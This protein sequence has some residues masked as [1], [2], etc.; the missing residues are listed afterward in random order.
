MVMRVP[1]LPSFSPRS[2]NDCSTDTSWERRNL[3]MGM[4]TWNSA[5][6]DPSS[7]SAEKITAGTGGQSGA[8]SGCA[9]GDATCPPPDPI[10]EP[11][12]QETR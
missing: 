12:R 3:R 9:A 7:T 10:M 6:N 5:A 8:G 2:P 11:S 1:P 4:S